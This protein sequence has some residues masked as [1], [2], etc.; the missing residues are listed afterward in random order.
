MNDFSERQILGRLSLIHEEGV[1]PVCIDEGYMKV[2][3]SDEVS[4][5]SFTVTMLSHPKIEGETAFEFRSSEGRQITGAA[6]HVLQEATEEIPVPGP[7]FRIIRDE[8]EDEWRPNHHRIKLQT[9]DSRFISAS[10]PFQS[11]NWKNLNPN[12]IGGPDWV[13][14]L[15]PKYADQAVLLMREPGEAEPSDFILEVIAPAP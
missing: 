10:E 3:F 4:G 11:P 8:V 1:Y 7:A 2:I 5:D 9:L 13:W 12:R 15:L 6:D 14:R